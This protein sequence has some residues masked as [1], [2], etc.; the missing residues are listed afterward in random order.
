MDRL[1]RPARPSQV[2]ALLLLISLSMAST[3]FAAAP[4]WVQATPFGGPMETVAAS[5]SSPQT[6][7][8][9][10]VVAGRFFR[11]LDGGA[12]WA[13]R[14]GGLGY[15]VTADLF[16]DAQDSRTVYA[17]TSSPD[18]PGVQRTRN[19]GLTWTAAGP[20]PNVYGLTLDDRAPGLLYAAT[21]RGLYR[22]ADAGDTWT[23]TAFAGSTVFAFAVDPRDPHTFLVA[24]GGSH[25][26]DPTTFRRS[27][28]QGATWVPATLGEAP[29]GLS[30]IVLRILFDPAH[31]GTA[32]A[33]LGPQTSQ[34]GTVFRTTD[35][36]A[37]WT[38]LDSTA[39]IRDLLPSPDG[40]LFAAADFGVS[41]STD[42]G[43][44]WVPPLPAQLTPETAPRDILA[45]L[46][47]SP[48]S[49]QTL[50]A[51]G[52][53][54][55]WKSTNDGASWAA[56]SQG[57]AALNV[58]SL[59]AAPAGPDN[60]L[61]VAGDGVFRS[62]DQAGTWRRVHSFFN[63][64]QPDTI[65]AFDPRNPQTVYGVGFDGQAD[66]LVESTNGGDDWRVLPVGYTCGGDSI[67]DVQMPAFAI[68]PQRTGNLYLG[69]VA[70]I[71]FQGLSEHLLHSSD[72]GETWKEMTPLHNLQ[73]LSIDPR[74]GK[75]LYGLTCKGLYESENAGSNWRQMGS[76]L[77]PQSLCAPNIPG[78]QRLAI[79]PRKPQNLYVGT[80]GHGVF[81]STDG[82]VTFRA[83]NQGLTTSD[84]TTILVDPATENL[85]A[86]ARGKGVWRWAAASRRWTPLNDGLPVWDFAGVLALDPQ[87]PSIL[88]AG[89][90]AHGVYRLDLGQ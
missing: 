11:S 78:R 30:P 61:A 35:D 58:S 44:T 47:F 39:G 20:G 27:T 36:G 85:Y 89:T 48:A 41:R 14:P 88:Y 72:G 23:A 69:V 28:D 10:T 26:S 90:V 24:V 86:A 52:T 29:P 83:F 56:A 43:D 18:K 1:H 34:L 55:I 76:G 45:R 4:H 12:T 59:A 50:F 54:G 2:L 9:A 66:F 5:P 67:C 84:V 87:D 80:A 8:A 17:R 65:E 57:I 7:Y 68:D 82:G 21:Q 81:R 74:Q 49:P 32:Y 15:V 79:D 46:A 63:G 77:P 3:A 70:F 51:A 6:V 42:R 31:A 71:H 62:P 60:L 64:P 22:S 19:G 13:E 33:F 75:T 38:F 37:S 40:T 53:E 16:V 25:S 73:A